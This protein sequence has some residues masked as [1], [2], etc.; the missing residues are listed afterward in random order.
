MGLMGSAAIPQRTS[1]G[2]REWDEWG[3]SKYWGLELK[4]D[5][6][7]GAK[8]QSKYRVAI[9]GEPTNDRWTPYLWALPAIGRP[10]S[11]LHAFLMTD[12]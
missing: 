11:T 5:R 3:L 1:T 2:D 4:G 7:G 8:T 10:T 12:G 9:H 6:N